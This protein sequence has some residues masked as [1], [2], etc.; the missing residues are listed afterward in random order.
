MNVQFERRRNNE[1]HPPVTC[2]QVVCVALVWC[3]AMGIGLWLCTDNG[4]RFLALLQR[5]L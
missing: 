2:M 1:P 5:A 3:A 4:I